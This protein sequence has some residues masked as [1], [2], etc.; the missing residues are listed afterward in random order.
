[1]KAVAAFAHNCICDGES[2][3]ASQPR[4][5]VHPQC[6]VRTSE[7]LGLTPRIYGGGSIII[8][9]AA[10]NKSR[11]SAQPR[12]PSLANIPQRETRIQSIDGVGGMGE[13]QLW[14]L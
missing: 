3:W 4:P 7:S 8:E 6:V 11:H 9:H 13:E 2:E 14:P 1:M 10:L 5:V 12:A